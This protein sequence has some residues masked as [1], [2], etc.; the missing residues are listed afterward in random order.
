MGEPRCV[1]SRGRG[2][3][4]SR[5][6]SRRRSRAASRCRAASYDTRL[7]WQWVNSPDDDA[8]WLYDGA[9]G[10]T[11]FSGDGA[12]AYPSRTLNRREE[13]ATIDN[14]PAVV[15]YTKT[16]EVRYQDHP[17]IATPE[18]RRCLHESVVTP[19]HN[20]PSQET[21]VILSHFFPYHDSPPHAPLRPTPARTWLHRSTRPP[22]RH[23]CIVLILLGVLLP[24]IEA[25]EPTD[26]AGFPCGV[27]A[28]YPELAT[29]ND[30]IVRELGDLLLR[31]ADN[32]RG[33]PDAL[34]SGRA[35]FGKLTGALD[36]LGSP[37]SLPLLKVLVGE[38]SAREKG[39]VFIRP[40]YRDEEDEPLFAWIAR[41]QQETLNS[42][43]LRM[44]RENEL[45]KEGRIG[46]VIALCWPGNHCAKDA[47]ALCALDR[48]EDAH[49]RIAILLRLH[50]LGGTPPPAIA[51]L[52][53]E[54]FEQIDV[55]AAAALAR[56]GDVQGVRLIQSGLT[57]NHGRID[58][59]AFLAETAFELTGKAVSPFQ[60]APS[61]VPRALEELSTW[62]GAHP[63]RAK[64]PLWTEYE[65]YMQ[66]E[67]RKRESAIESIEGLVAAPE[68]AI[69]LAAATMLIAGEADAIRS[70][71]LEQINRLAI[72]LR[73]RLAGACDVESKVAVLNAALLNARPTHSAPYGV[74]RVSFLPSVLASAHG[75]CLG[76]STLYLAVAERLGLPVV[77]IALP[78]HVLVRWDDGTV[79]RNIETTKSGANHSDEEYAAGIEGAAPMVSPESLQKG[80]C[81]RKLRKREFLAF[82]CCNASSA[83]LS[84]GDHEEAKRLADLG[85]R[86]DA[87]CGEA[88]EARAWAVYM[89]RPEQ[90]AGV[91]SDIDRAL[92]YDPS[93]A[94]ALLL[95]ARVLREN[96]STARALAAAC[97]AEE[98][99]RPNPG[100]HP[101]ARIEKAR[102]LS[103]LGNHD[104][105]LRVLASGSAG[106]AEAR[107]A[108]EDACV[109]VR[110][111]RNIEHVESFLAESLRADSEAV[112]IAAQVLLEKT[113]A[114]APDPGRALSL[115]KA[116]S[117][118]NR[119]GNA[120]APARSIEERMERN[121]KERR[122]Q[123]LIAEAS[124]LLGNHADARAARR[125]VELLERTY[126]S[127][128]AQYGAREN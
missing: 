1:R 30:E 18:L 17:K 32:G 98:I 104:E 33:T 5:S 46:S 72:G 39:N 75:D 34:V 113:D 61:L 2:R 126:R 116:V 96:G 89:T 24:R 128:V 19:M 109:E 27:L 31:A 106:A 8:H 118:S 101:S 11:H 45:H 12:T 51:E 86:F 122:R 66:S 102:C 95:K 56:M 74:E 49:V 50:R 111:R 108:I 67:Q 79:A 59:A 117:F 87:E 120:G 58:V 76:Y 15:L 69:D 29:C 41:L 57:S 4:V 100:L 52:L 77:A 35:R 119:G 40:Y 85:I 3:R 44:L 88:Y 99:L 107:S 92:G 115:L 10:I 20:T 38:Y 112:L 82:V 22:R 16:G 127:L 84:K 36:R 23:R 114:R 21:H 93:C 65:A 64:T 105:A 53:Y 9:D 26:S 83:A 73:R 14:T 63:D 68:D 42:L 43:L 54:P 94:R 55:T 81:L 70:T 47:L 7:S 71:V 125:T 60:F 103:L 80:R 37:A 90:V 124:E 28:R 78:H 97:T 6:S 91:L 110:V 123:T 62:L 13:I 25:S 121:W 48:R